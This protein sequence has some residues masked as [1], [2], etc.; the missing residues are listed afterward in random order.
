MGIG[1]LLKLK[2]AGKITPEAYAKAATDIKN[3]VPIDEINKK[4][5]KQMNTNRKSYESEA[6]SFK[7]DDNN[8]AWVNGEAQ[9]AK[10]KDQNDAAASSIG[11]LITKTKGGTREAPANVEYT[12]KELSGRAKV[13]LAKH[14]DD[15]MSKFGGWVQ[16][17][18][19]MDSISYKINNPGAKADPKVES[20]VKSMDESLEIV[21]EALI[22]VGITPNVNSLKQLAGLNTRIQNMPFSQ[23]KEIVQPLVKDGDDKLL[24]AWK[25]ARDGEEVFSFNFIDDAAQSTYSKSI[26]GDHY[27]NL[28]AY[29]DKQ[30]AQSAATQ[31]FGTNPKAKMNALIDDQVAKGVKIS[32]K[33]REILNNMYES[34]TGTLSQSMDPSKAAQTVSNLRGVATGSMLGGSPVMSLMDVPFSMTTLSENGLGFAKFFQAVIKGLVS[35]G[36]RIS[37]ARL[38]H[39][40]DG[41]ETAL[42]LTSKF[43]PHASTSNLV[44]KFATSTLRLGGLIA[45]GDVLKN[46]V[47][48]TFYYSL[49]DFK[50]STFAGLRKANPKF[51]KKMVQYG[52]NEDD[53]NTIRKSMSD[54][55]MMFNPLNVHDDVG[56]KIFRMVNE[57]GDYAVVT[58]GARSNYVTSLGF[59]KGTLAGEGLKAFTQ[60]KSTIVEQVITHLYRA[61]QQ[62][63][64]K[65]KLGYSA[66]MLVGTSVV[67]A[68]VMEIK[69]VTAGRTPI[70]PL[71]QPKKFISGTVEKA[72]LVPGISDMLVPRLLDPKF[73]DGNIWTEMITPAAMSL[74]TNATYHLYQLLTAANKEKDLK[75]KA[76]LYRDV[77]R[78]FPNFW[79]TNMFYK[80]FVVN[81]GS[82][83]IDP[84]GQ[85]KRM[86]AQDKRLKKDDQK[87]FMDFK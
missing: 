87:Y 16:P 70:N 26:G 46:A 35:K 9:S 11:D 24:E 39:Q 58:P 77:A 86:R 76:A 84:A 31:V 61:A 48:S 5:D 78:I 62:T 50:G 74:P 12:A 47:K 30:S 45:F 79:Y 71:T 29:I 8:K 22:N 34:A 52:V 85:K 68:M 4:L 18:K 56:S 67:G 17:G 7:V 27:S 81:Y 82:T 41:I 20:I 33:Q 28:M 40:I 57:E 64:V 3:N 49:R 73:T 75:A 83:L 42:N 59:D 19:M 53:W 44:N 43:N 1:C 14:F 38:G 36:D 65:N 15:L 66:Q 23:F 55:D 6:N 25:A 54:D 63:G 32:T 13:P 60:F 51:H 10:P 80:E 37:L 21:N 72:G 2:V 69:E